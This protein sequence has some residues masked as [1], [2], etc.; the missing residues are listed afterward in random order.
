MKDLHLNLKKEYFEEI[1]S[2]VKKFEYRL[3]NDYWIKRLV[4]KR[5]NKLF[6]KCGYPKKNDKDKILEFPY[7]GYELR[8]IRHEHFGNTNATDKQV[9]VFAIIVNQ[10]LG[11]SN[12]LAR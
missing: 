2:G 9:K 12:E 4:G 3:Y 6:I 8:D 7:I 1:K 10:D 5:Y 11:F